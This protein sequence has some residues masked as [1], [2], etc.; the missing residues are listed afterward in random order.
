MS[1]EGEAFSFAWVIEEVAGVYGLAEFVV[2]CM[3]W[4][5]GSDLDWVGGATD[6]PPP[7]HS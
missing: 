5:S 7:P 2:V 3:G 4:T 6:P 1:F